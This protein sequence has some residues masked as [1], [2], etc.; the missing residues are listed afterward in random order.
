MINLMTQTDRPTS[1]HALKVHPTI[2][3]EQISD[4]VDRF[5]A[6]IRT[7][8]D[9]CPIFESHIGDAWDPHLDKMKKF[10]RSILLKSRE[11]EGRPV[12]VHQKIEGLETREFEIW[13]ALFS[14]T[15]I[16]TMHPEAADITIELAKRVATS[17]WLSRFPDPTVS[18][19]Q[20]NTKEIKVS[21][22]HNG[23][24]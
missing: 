22:T 24:S 21:E 23:N 19:P 14:K 13:L 6:A 2:T 10:W 3:E 18:P 7:D 20:W 8:A 17:L 4:L 16:Q 9:L 12:P 1:L 15:A 11:Y 5:Y